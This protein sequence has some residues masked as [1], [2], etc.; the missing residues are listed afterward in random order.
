MTLRTGSG[1][2]RGVKFLGVLALACAFAS[3]MTLENRR[4]LYTADFDLWPVSR[5]ATASVQTTTT[6]PSP[7]IKTRKTAPEVKPI[8]NEPEETPNLPEPLP[9]PPP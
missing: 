9:P 5:P 2:I 6:T 7:P 1:C 4:D 3:C 8:P